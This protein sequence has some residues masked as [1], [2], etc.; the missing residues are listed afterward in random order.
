LSTSCATKRTAPGHARV[1]D[2]AACWNR[3]PSA[4]ARKRLDLPESE[5]A[6]HV[7]QLDLFAATEP[8]AATAE[9]VPDPALAALDAADPDALSPRQALDLL[10]RLESMRPTSAHD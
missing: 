7:A 9:P 8:V 5:H 10:Y 3:Q 2:C 4:G 6:R 1:A